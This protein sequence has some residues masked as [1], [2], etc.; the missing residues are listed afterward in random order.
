MVAA[1]F[2]RAYARTRKYEGGNDDDPR[3]PGGR[4]SRGITQRE[5]SAWRARR[6]EPS[7]DVWS[8]SEDEVA[9]IYREDYWTKG[10]CDALPAGVDFVTYDAN[11]NSGLGKGARWLQQALNDNNIPVLVDDAI[12][13]QTV[14]GAIRAPDKTAIVRAETKRRSAFLHSLRTWSVFGKGWGRRVADVEVY[15]VQLA[16]EGAGMPPGQIATELNN[17]ATEAA[18]TAS[19]HQQGAGGAVVAGGGSAV[20]GLPDWMVAIAIL[21]I[22]GATLWFSFHARRNNQRAAAYK[23]AAAAISTEGK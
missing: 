23:A 22:V 9:A 14:A 10:K 19:S 1:N 8:A 7:R 20:A 15:G 21:V 18:N 12:G 5:Y 11:V 13:T 3:D 4:T 2:A 6:G 16:L 17:H